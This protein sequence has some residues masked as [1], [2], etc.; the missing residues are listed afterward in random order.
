[1][2]Q[3]CTLKRKIGSAD[4]VKKI[5]DAIKAYRQPSRLDD[6]SESELAADIL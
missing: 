1:M 2:N 6:L 4:Q 3:L 5:V